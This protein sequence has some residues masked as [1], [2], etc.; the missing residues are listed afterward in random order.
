[1]RSSAPNERAGQQIQQNPL[2]AFGISRYSPSSINPHDPYGSASLIVEFHNR[3]PRHASVGIFR[4]IKEI[5][6]RSSD[7]EAGRH[8]RAPSMGLT[9]AASPRFPARVTAR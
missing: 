8:R 6:R 4:Q 5:E 3:L 7:P 9:Q 1:V 2:T